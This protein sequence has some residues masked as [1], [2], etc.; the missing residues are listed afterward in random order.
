MPSKRKFEV[1]RLR[2]SV[3]H[4]SLLTGF[5]SHRLETQFWVGIPSALTGPKPNLTRDETEIP[6]IAVL[7][8]V[9]AGAMSFS[10][11]EEVLHKPL[12]ASKSL[13]CCVMGRDRAYGDTRFAE[14]VANI[15][16]NG[17]YS[18]NNIQKNDTERNGKPRKIVEDTAQ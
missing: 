14:A 3:C 13:S 10:Y 1:C 8:A 12:C 2:Y 17:T 16:R 15:P 4:N 6:G 7:L 11:R 9:V 18:R 5:G